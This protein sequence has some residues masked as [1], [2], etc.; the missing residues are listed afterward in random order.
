MKRGLLC[1]ISIQFYKKSAKVAS[2]RRQQLG[3]SA[4]QKLSKD[5][6]TAARKFS[7]DKGFVFVVTELPNFRAAELLHY[8]EKNTEK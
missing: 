6:R 8:A 2:R 7:K 4:A 5:K 1:F 3:S